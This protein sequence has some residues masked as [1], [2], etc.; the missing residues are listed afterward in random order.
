MAKKKILLIDDDESYTKMIKMHLERTGKYEVTTENDEKQALAA[1]QKAN[2]D[3]ILLD[4]MFPAT[5]GGEIA[6]RIES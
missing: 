1:V 4:I 5:D 3:L 6:H 2:P